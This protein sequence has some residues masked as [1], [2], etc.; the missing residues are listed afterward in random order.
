[1]A[2][3]ALH[4][5]QRLNALRNSNET[6]EECISAI[7]EIKFY[8]F[9]LIPAFCL[10]ILMAFTMN[11]TQRWKDFLR[12]RPGL[13]YPMD[14]MTRLSRLSYCAA[15]GATAFLVYQITIQRQFAINYDGPISLKALIAIVSML[16]YGMVFFPIFACLALRTAFG[17]AL[18]SLYIWVFFIIDVISLDDCAEDLE[19]RKVRLILRFL[20]SVICR[21]FLSL[22]LPVKFVMACKKGSYFRNVTTGNTLEKTLDQVRDSYQGRHVRKLLRKK[23]RKQKL[24]GVKNKIKSLFA[25]IWSLFYHREK[26]Y[27]FQSRFVSMLFVGGCVVYILTVEFLFFALTLL[28]YLNYKLDQLGNTLEDLFGY[29]WQFSDDPDYQEFIGD[30]GNLTLAVEIVLIQATDVVYYSIIVS[31][32][33]SC[34]IIL[35]NILHMCTSFRK[36]LFTLYKG[37]DSLIP[38]ASEFSSINLCVGSIKFGGFQVAYLIWG[39]VILTIVLTLVCLVLGGFISVLIFGFTDWLVNKVLQIWPG[40]LVA[41]ALLIIQKLL[42]RFLFLQGDGQHL[43]LDNRRFYFIFTYFM[44][45]YNIF[46][47]IASC[48]L[49]IIKSLIFGIICLC[50]LDIST[51]PRKFEGFD[52]GFTAY[53]GYIHM[54]VAHTHPVVL[55][56]IQL[57]YTLSRKR[58]GLDPEPVESYSI[59]M[60]RAIR[61]RAAQFNWLVLYTLLHNPSVRIYR[62]GFIQSMRK[63]IKEGL[64]IPI[65]DQPIT[66]FDL[67]KLQEERDKEEQEL[68]KT[69]KQNGATSP[70]IFNLAPVNFSENYKNA[71]SAHAYIDMKQSEKM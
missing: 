14:T 27:R 60:K 64:K 39:Y 31:C 2:S 57:L 17:Y 26:G 40:L 55:V 30:L 71:Y 12:G 1:M 23:E 10:T 42:A 54:E 50:R 5:L 3:T 70:T 61:N 52:P 21:A 13:V 37:D 46:L 28:K 69:N 34:A 29:L 67:V 47:G 68:A 18:G 16:I 65:S 7:D 45:F 41:I 56:F 48:L 25:K 11:R 36:N 6:Q 20:P 38:L 32:T 58:K 8:Q 44:F 66:D 51:L 9:S 22:S 33:L 24:V 49:R 15:F 63:A 35:I 4:Y 53:K 62:K 59:P 43:R 19:K